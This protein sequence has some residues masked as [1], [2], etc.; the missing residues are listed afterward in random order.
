MQQQEE[1]EEEQEKEE[2]EEEEGETNQKQLRRVVLWG[3]A[4]Q[5]PAV[6]LLSWEEMFC[7]TLLDSPASVSTVLDVLCWTLNLWQLYSSI[8]SLNSI[9][10]A[11]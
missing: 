5:Q 2:E 1:E 7:A 4:E 11:Y 8:A 9:L 10:S 6:A 3:E